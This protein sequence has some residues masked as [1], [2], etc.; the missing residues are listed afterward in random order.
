MKFHKIGCRADSPPFDERFVGYG[1]TRNTQVTT[2]AY[3]EPVRLSVRV[4]SK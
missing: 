4:L 1:M 2:G 3:L